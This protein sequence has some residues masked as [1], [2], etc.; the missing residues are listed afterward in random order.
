MQLDA[1]VASTNT[2]HLFD[3]WS[4]E[5]RSS[6]ERLAWKRVLTGLGRFPVYREL[7]AARAASVDPSRLPLLE[8]RHLT[9]AFPASWMNE[10]LEQAI[11]AGAVEFNSTSGSSGQRVHL[12]RQRDWWR[13]EHQRVFPHVTAL[14][15]FRVGIDRKAILTTPDCFSG[16]CGTISDAPES[17]TVGS[18][19]FLSTARDPFDWTRDTVRRILVELHE[20][21]PKVLDANPHFLAVL[22]ARR[23]Q[24]ELDVPVY[25]PPI[26]SLDYQRVSRNQ[27]RIIDE[28]FEGPVVN[29]YGTTELGCLGYES[30]TEGFRRLEPLS[31]VEYVEHCPSTSTFRL[32]IS[33]IKN[34]YMPFIRLMTDDL[35]RLCDPGDPSA[36]FIVCGRLSD[37]VRL[38]SGAIF[39]P[40]DLDAI[41]GR[42]AAVLAHRLRVPS[43]GALCLELVARGTSNVGATC[44]LE[45]ASAVSERFGGRRVDVAHRDRIGVASSG[46]SVEMVDEAR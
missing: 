40:E 33:S 6:D 3:E 41:V 20:F 8:R 9:S 16:I 1:S 17:R 25:Q 19:R 7:H 44:A 34:R 4:L 42:H 23:E 13:H 18:L 37:S 12:V 5:S 29:L 35:V 28:S 27:R 30:G 26:L 21:A 22:L 14:Q 39:T 10:E 31:I 32:V 24:L 43:E 11:E 45:L 46:K 15:G 2:F 38:P 36:G